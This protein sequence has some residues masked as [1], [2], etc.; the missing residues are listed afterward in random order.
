M[1][2][3][4]KDSYAIT[5][6]AL[7]HFKNHYKK[8][9]LSKHLSSDRSI[10]N[11]SYGR[12]DSRFRGN[13]SLREN[14][15]QGGNDSVFEI[16]EQQTN[17]A[18]GS[19]DTKAIAVGQSPSFPSKNSV[20]QQL[21]KETKSS[22]E[23]SANKSSASYDFKEPISKSSLD[24]TEK[25]AKKESSGHLKILQK[26]APNNDKS[27]IGNLKVIQKNPDSITKEDI[28]YY[29]Y[30]LLHSEDY[31]NRY[32]S[33]LDKALPHIPLV[34]EFWE[35]ASIGRK[36]ADLHLNYEHQS[37]P[38]EVKILKDGQEIDIS[39]FNNPSSS[40]QSIHTKSTNKKQTWG[41]LSQDQEKQAISFQKLLPLPSGLSLEDL[42][43]TKMKMDKNDQ[44]TVRFNEHITITNIPKEA[45]DYKVNGWSAPKWIMNRYQYKKDKKT[46]L[47]NDPNTYSEDPAYV[48]KLLLSVMTVSIKTQELVQ[49]LPS[50]DFDSL[51]AFMD[52]TG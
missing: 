39:Y 20:H 24:R 5:D 51:T 2:K 44:S 29:I 19:L 34:P 3:G 10:S 46:D 37:P 9:S 32:K 41:V 21:N 6:S 47:V 43:V 1:L 33:N 48:L 49:S 45:W 14:D 23:V 36:L 27:I 12:P 18:V 25:L 42:K 52:K 30:G 7:N 4:N 50:I 38:K 13:D 16:E 40:E 8:L 17:S 26:N 11:K 35:F 28:F 22:S 31:R 15:R